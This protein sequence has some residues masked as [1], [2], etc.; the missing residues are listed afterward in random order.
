MPRKVTKNRV[1]PNLQRRTDSLVPQPAQLSGWARD[2]PVRPSFSLCQHYFM[3]NPL[4]QEGH[5]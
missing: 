4:R 1:W 3:P 5:L 2:V